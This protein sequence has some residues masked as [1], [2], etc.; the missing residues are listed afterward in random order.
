MEADVAKLHM[1]LKEYEDHERQIAEVMILAQISAQRT[2]AQA[3]AKAEIIMQ[4]ADEKLRRRHQELELLRLK[5][6]R[7]RKELYARLDLYQA[8]L[9]QIADISEE[10]A[11]THTLISRDK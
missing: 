6:K 4:E 8:A 11:F 7:F 2:E 3:R 9:D 5:A 10:F 1:K